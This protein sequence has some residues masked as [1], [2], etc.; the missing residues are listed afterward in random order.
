MVKYIIKK[1][2]LLFIPVITALIFLIASCNDEPTIMGSS[3]L[4]DT[5]AIKSI[6]TDSTT[7]IVDS[8]SYIHRLEIFNSGAIFIGK[9]NDVIAISMIRFS[10]IPDTL[11]NLTEA[12]IDSV[13]LTLPLLRYAYGDSLNQNAL[14]FK[15]Y[16]IVK[17]WS[18]QS[19]WDTL[20]PTGSQTEYFDYTKLLG[21]FN[22]TINQK[23]TNWN[24]LSIQIDKQLIAEWFKL[25]SDTLTAGTIWGIALVPDDNA[26]VIRSLSSQ[27]LI[28]TRVH[29]YIR[30]TY[31]RTQDKLDTLILS[32]AI[33]ASVTN[34]NPPDEKSLTIQGI[35]SGRFKMSF[36]VSSIP[37]E[38]A[39]HVAELDLYLDRSASN[40]GNFGLDDTLLVRLYSDSTYKSYYF[41]HTGRNDTLNTNLYRFP[42]LTDAVQY[43]V[44]H[45]KKGELVF[46][47]EGL[48]NEY[49]EFDKLVFRGLNDP[50]KSKRPAMRIIYSTRPK[51][52]NKP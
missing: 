50:D 35:V 13:T 14:S 20:F 27:T 36:D 47:P 15:V 29:P 34:S 18:N 16:K 9:S 10:G 33:D 45:G 43:W 52:R 6:S 26:T 32:S 44:T 17:Y 11:G 38:A 28:E 5:I 23:D 39:V 8:K 46:L 22:G 40:H 7:L 31:R 4:L 41:Y 30:I 12:D 49:R 42:E 21:T 51:T 37:D 2:R 3:L 24:P 48:E 25:A 1:K 19:S